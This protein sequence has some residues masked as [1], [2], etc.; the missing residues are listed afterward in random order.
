[1]NILYVGYYTEQNIARKR[2]LDEC[3]SRNIINPLVHKIILVA[4]ETVGDIVFPFE[5]VTVHHLGHRPTFQD[6]FYGVVPKYS[7][8]DTINIISNSDIYFD[9]TLK[10]LNYVDWD[11]GIALALSRYDK[12]NGEWT[13]FPQR[14]RSSSKNKEGIKI[15]HRDYRETM[16]CYS[17]DVWVFK[18]NIKGMFANFPLGSWGCDN[19]IAYEM[20]K[21]GYWVFN[22][23]NEIVCRHIH[24]DSL[25]QPRKDTDYTV[26]PPYRL[27]PPVGFHM[28]KTKQPLK[29]YHVGMW[30][31]FAAEGS[32]GETL[33][34]CGEYRFTDWLKYTKH[35][36]AYSIIDRPAFEQEVL[37][38][39]EW[40]DVVFMQLQTP[41][42]IT[43]DLANRMN[44]LC[45][46]I[47]NWDGDKRAE[48]PQWKKDIAPYV[49]N[50]WSNADDVE[51]FRKLGFKAEYMNTI[52]S[53]TKY[54]PKGYVDK[55]VPPIVFLANNYWDKENKIHAFPLG[56]ERQDLA[57]FLTETY[58]KNF[59]LWG[60]GWDG[61]ETGN[62]NDDCIRE[63]SIYRG[64]K[65]GINFSQFN[66]SRYSSDRMFRIMGSGCFCL[67]HHYKDIEVDFEIGKQLDTFHDLN[68]LK[69][70][71]DY[72]LAHEE[73]RAAIAKCGSE[74]V[75]KNYGTHKLYSKILNLT[76]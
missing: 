23:S 12:V 26:Q 58:G 18:G 57:L 53:P 71:I 17:Q 75:H 8:E 61:I 67:S 40:A 50:L 76:Q 54:N 22:L 74:Y 65:I 14:E 46:R 20:D 73:E 69:E 19:R 7:D 3:L 28:I 34:E 72:Y 70:K 45:K 68:E 39:C 11:S 44:N 52:F 2:E 49:T 32:M 36:Q 1:M 63:A 10:K 48:I 43:A 24:S 15:F 6:I 9:E 56:K 41:D 47:Y 59:G 16:D 13:N 33:Q 66:S 4:D 25:R 60:H 21:A 27:L 5:K 31:F 29:I 38:G 62:L 42:I 37:Q 55:D 30:S 51:T 35:P 64:A